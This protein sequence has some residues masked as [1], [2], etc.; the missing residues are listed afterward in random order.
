MGLVN[1]F[2]ECKGTTNFWI[3]QEKAQ[4]SYISFR[5][6]PIIEMAY[7]FSWRVATR[8]VSLRCSRSSISKNCITCSCFCNRHFGND[9]YIFFKFAAKVQQIFGI[10]KR[11][12]YFFEK[13]SGLSP[14]CKYWVAIGSLLTDS[15]SVLT[16]ARTIV[17]ILKKIPRLC[18]CTAGCERTFE[19]GR[20][21]C[22]CPRRYNKYLEYARI[23]R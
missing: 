20:A 13:K 21:A 1:L 5:D 3:A 15:Y 17:R 11:S 6:S 22:R 12:G 2:F 18:I 7:F 14:I 19:V 23:C 10:C 4:K 9:H 16:N 8:N